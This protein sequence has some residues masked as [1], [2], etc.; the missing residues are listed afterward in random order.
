[1]RILSS[2]VPPHPLFVPSRQS[3]CG[4]CRAVRAKLVGDQNIRRKTLFLKQLAYEF[5]G[6]SLVASPLHKEVENLAFVVNRA[7]QPELPSPDHYN[8]LIEMPS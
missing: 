1:M 7:P 3:H 4:L 5:H 6:R 2:I 8:H